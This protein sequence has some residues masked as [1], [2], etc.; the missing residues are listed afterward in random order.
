MSSEGLVQ[1]PGDEVQRTFGR[2]EQVVV[3]AVAEEGIVVGQPGIHRHEAQQTVEVHLAFHGFDEGR[4]GGLIQV[5]EQAHEP[6]RIGR[7]DG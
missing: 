4:V 7:S 5:P 1:I 6:A 3:M 2:H